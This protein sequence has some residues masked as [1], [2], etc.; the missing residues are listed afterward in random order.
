VKQGSLS[1]TKRKGPFLT[2]DEVV[3]SQAGCTQA[4][5]FT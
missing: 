2:E 4:F 3:K 1:T 5:S